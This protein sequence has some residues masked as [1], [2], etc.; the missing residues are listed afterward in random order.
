MG[1]KTGHTWQSAPWAPTCVLRP[2][3]FLSQV[4]PHKPGTAI[5]PPEP[6]QWGIAALPLGQTHLLELLPLDRTCSNPFQPLPQTQSHKTQNPGHTLKAIS[7]KAKPRVGL[8]LN[9]T[10]ESQTEHWG[11]EIRE[12]HLPYW[13]SPAGVHSLLKKFQER[14]IDFFSIFLIFFYL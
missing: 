3:S 14:N 6:L 12:G 10:G 11:P 2:F 9:P 13:W 8:W 7:R 1:S 5:P 4:L